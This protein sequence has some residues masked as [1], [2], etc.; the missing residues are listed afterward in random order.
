MTTTT[1]TTT[2]TTSPTTTSTR[3]PTT[4]STTLDP[5]QQ[6][7]C[8]NKDLITCPTTVGHVCASDGVIYKNDCEFAKAKCSD[9]SLSIQSISL[10]NQHTTTSR[11]TTLDA[12]QQ[13]FCDNKDFI[14]CPSTTKHVCASDGVVYNNDCEFAKAK[15]TN[16]ALTL[17][18]PHFVNTPTEHYS[19]LIFSHT[20]CTRKTALF[21]F[22]LRNPVRKY[23]DQKDSIGDV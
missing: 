12:N 11:P 8:D 13:L 18:P 23:S 1:S 17:Q 21:S 16:G 14:S 3:P 22:K 7:F 2:T 19:T 6:L 9:G 4:K 10:C 15:C 5:N 20:T